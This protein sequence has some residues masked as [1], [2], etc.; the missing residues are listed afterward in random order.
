MDLSIVVPVRNEAE[1]ILPLISEIHGALSGRLD[2]EIVYVNDGSDDAT[3]EQL[4]KARARFPMLRVLTHDRAYGQS[5]AV[6]TGI[7]HAK[8][9]FVATLDG[10]G[11]NDPASI[12]AMWDR[13]RQA[14]AA[15]TNLVIC[16]FRKNRKDTGMRRLASKIANGIRARMLGDA[17]PDSGCGLKLFSREAFLDLPHFDHMHRFLPALF[18]RRGCTVVSVEVHHRP[19]ERGVSKYGILDRLW[20]GIWDLLGV[21]WLQRRTRY[22]I[23]K[24]EE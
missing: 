11:Q 22:P 16:G 19:R 5:R 21:M 15:D 20:A 10:D 2:F 9:K 6:V 17:T 4:T 13:L 3:A 18:M 1:N 12:P 7:K 23:I 14:G 24:K 8:A